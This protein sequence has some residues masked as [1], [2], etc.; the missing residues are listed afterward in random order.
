[1]INIDGSLKPFRMAKEDLIKLLKKIDKKVKKTDKHYTYLYVVVIDKISN[2]CNTI[3]ELT[4]FLKDL[5][6]PETI[7]NLKIWAS[8][9]PRYYLNFN[10]FLA[11]YNISGTTNTAVAKSIEALIKNC[12]K[13]YQVSRFYSGLNGLILGLF[14]LGMLLVESSLVIA[15]LIYP[16]RLP[17]ILIHL[18][19]TLASLTSICYLVWSNFLTPQPPS[20]F[21]SH[22]AIYSNKIPKKS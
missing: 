11:T 13:R 4:L 8:T 21:F 3:D 16:T 1:M 15:F 10:S 20:H 22:S 5:S 2:N 14:L 9:E 12:F 17:Y 19:T 7:R 6:T 18:F